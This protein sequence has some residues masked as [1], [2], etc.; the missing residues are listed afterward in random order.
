MREYRPLIITATVGVAFL[1]WWGWFLRVDGDVNA[2]VNR[3]GISLFGDSLDRKARSLSD[4][5]SK[6]CGRVPTTGDHDE[7]TRCALSAFGEHRPFRVRYDR[8][9]LD[10]V[11]SVGLVSRKTG[12][13]YLLLVDDFSFGTK[14]A[15]S[16]QIRPCPQPAVLNITKMGRLTCYPEGE[17]PYR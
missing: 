15:Q 6:N 7:V 1:V 8:Q 9:G 16:V 14:W 12:E 5:S 10:S 13:M 11:L 2:L 17:T 4:W 3:T